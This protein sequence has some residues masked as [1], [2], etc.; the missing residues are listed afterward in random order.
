[1]SRR[2]TT[3]ICSGIVPTDPSQNVNRLIPTIYEDE[4]KP[5]GSQD[6][7]SKQN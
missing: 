5:T 1:M 7:R 3:H 6:P 2:N 4:A